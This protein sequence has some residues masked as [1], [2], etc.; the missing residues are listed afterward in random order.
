MTQRYYH[1][2]HR[3]YSR[4]RPC[5]ISAIWKKMPHRTYLAVSNGAQ[6]KIDPRISIKYSKTSL[7]KTL[8]GRPL[9]KVTLNFY[10]LLMSHLPFSSSVWVIISP[11][12]HPGFCSN[13][14]PG[15]FSRPEYSK[16]AA[17]RPASLTHVECHKSQKTL[18]FFF[19]WIWCPFLGPRFLKKGSLK[20]QKGTHST[21]IGQ[22]L[23]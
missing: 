8:I 20:L 15:F 23:E 3:V 9:Y 16:M 22:L 10:S 2:Y 7:T 11:D 14:S 5:G 19:F 6:K 17:Q 13:S 21:L 1:S 4:A 18:S 12:K